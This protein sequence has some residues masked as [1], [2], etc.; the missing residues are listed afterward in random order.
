MKKNKFLAVSLLII[1]VPVAVRVV[2]DIIV[3]PLIRG[4]YS[5]LTDAS[6]SYDTLYRIIDPSVN[7]PTY[8]KIAICTTLVLIALERLRRTIE[9]SRST[10]EKTTDK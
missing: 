7:S 3:S 8:I 5:L 9:Q 6:I 4:L 2:W 1:W 10:A